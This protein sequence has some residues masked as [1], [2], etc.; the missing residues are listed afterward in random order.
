MNQN[1]MRIR[2]RCHMK[3]RCLENVHRGCS[4]KADKI[5]EARQGQ[6]GWYV[7][8]DESGES[9][10]YPPHLFEVVEDDLMKYYKNHKDEYEI[11]F[12]R[13]SSNHQ[14]I[15]SIWECCFNDIMNLFQP[16][17]S[18][19]RGLAAIYHNKTGWYESDFWKIPYVM[20]ALREFRSLDEREL[21]LDDSG[22]ILKQICEFLEKAV[23][24]NEEVWISLRGND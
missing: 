13:Q 5:Y 3:I 12:I 4:L 23:E 9:Y 21:K 17:D 15:L 20:D 1:T 24:I 10:A 8:V 16:K 6:K 7:V 14:Y 22:I 18:I 19:W 2:R 11:R